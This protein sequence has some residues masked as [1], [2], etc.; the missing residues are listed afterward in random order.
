MQPLDKDEPARIRR[1]AAERVAEA[2]RAYRRSWYALVVAALVLGAFLGFGAGL[3]I[4]DHWSGGREV[5][6]IPMDGTDV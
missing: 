3:L 6:F 1:E 4:A 5:I 2:Q